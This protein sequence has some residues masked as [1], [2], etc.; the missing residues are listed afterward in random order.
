MT[1]APPTTV[2]TTTALT[3]ADIL[4]R[5]PHRHPFVMLDAVT[6][7][8]ASHSGTAIKNIS[9]SDP[10]FEGHFPG[11]PIYPGVLLVE[12]AAHLCGLVAAEVDGGETRIG[13]LASIKRFRFTTLVRPGDRVRIQAVAGT[14]FGGMSDFSVT[15][16]VDEKDVASGSLVIALP[17]S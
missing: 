15:L 17:K 6:E 4:A 8:V 16:T 9:I 7:L 2:A 10:V 5:L 14:R 12:S 13:Y 1:A 11:E 3:A